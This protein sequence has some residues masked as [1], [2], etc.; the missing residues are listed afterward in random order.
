VSWLA[1]AAGIVAGLLALVSFIGLCF[2]YF[3]G[4]AD[5]GTIESQ[6]RQ[7]ETQATELETYSVRLTKA[8]TRVTSVESENRILRSAVAHVE[9]LVTLQNTLEHHHEE[10]ITVLTAIAAAVLPGG[11]K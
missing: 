7:L 3:R 5:K 6:R 4:S 2:V 9:E 1:A 10:S 11:K 8:E